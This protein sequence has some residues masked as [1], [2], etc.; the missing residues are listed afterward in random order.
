VVP[1]AQKDK[2]FFDVSAFLLP[3]KVLIVLNHFGGYIIPKRREFIGLFKF[4]LNPHSLV[5]K[6]RL[7]IHILPKSKIL[8]NDYLFFKGAHVDVFLFF[9]GSQINALGYALK[10]LQI[11]VWLNGKKIRAQILEWI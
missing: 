9:F 6:C 10:A 3:Q 8:L 5:G 1:P 2:L 11:K 4:P 7:F